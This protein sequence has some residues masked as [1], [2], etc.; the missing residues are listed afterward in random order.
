MAV[1]CGQPCAELETELTELLKRSVDAQLLA[2]NRW[3]ASSRRLGPAVAAESKSAGSLS[4]ALAGGGSRGT[5]NRRSHHKGG[6]RES[7]GPAT[8]LSHLL[9]DRPTA[10]VASAVVG[11]PAGAHH[12]GSTDRKSVV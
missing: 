2:R 10:P 5:T 4:S 3:Q 12:G 1:A 8:S 6:V 11:T 9:S 7:S